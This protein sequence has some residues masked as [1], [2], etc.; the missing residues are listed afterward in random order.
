[1]AKICGTLV[2]IW[3]ST[4]MKPLSVTVTPALLR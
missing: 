3:P 4:G 1:M 2:R